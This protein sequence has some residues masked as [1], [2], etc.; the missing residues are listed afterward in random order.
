[1]P[2]RH[3]STLDAFKHMP[4]HTLNVEGKN[5]FLEHSGA[6]NAVLKI[7]EFKHIPKMSGRFLNSLEASGVNMRE[8]DTAPLRHVVLFC[9]LNIVLLI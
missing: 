4:K 6:G 1:M 5:V 2:T 3:I 9:C 8:K 7:D